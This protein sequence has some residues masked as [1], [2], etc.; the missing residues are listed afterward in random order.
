MAHFLLDANMPR[1]AATVITAAGHTPIFLRDVGLR[2]A[3]D[4][5]IAEYARLN[6]CVIITRDFDFSDVRMFPP[7]DYAGIVVLQVPDTAESPM[8]CALVR[9]FFT[10]AEILS[11]LPGHLAIV[12]F[13][14]VR[15][16]AG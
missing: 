15:L 1:D 2:S 9:E 4:S 6:G 16:R 14:R 5:R 10:K 8:I 12:E 11:A 13:G 3:T 7:A